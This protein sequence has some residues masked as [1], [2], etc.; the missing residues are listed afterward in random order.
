MELEQDMEGRQAYIKA[1]KAL[2]ISGHEE[3]EFHPALVDDN[4]DGDS[5]C[6]IQARG[7]EVGVGG[8]DMLQCTQ[9]MEN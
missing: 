6:D 3:L 1:G 7:G 5:I 4:E 2:V 9:T 8:W